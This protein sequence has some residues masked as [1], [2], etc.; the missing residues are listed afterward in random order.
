[1]V[2]HVEGELVVLG[3]SR[4]VVQTGGVGFE[5]RIPLSTYTALK[6]K[7]GARV[8]ILTHLQVLEDDLRL[9]GFATERERDLFRLLTSINGV[10][11]ATAL[12][13]LA[14]IDPAAFAALIAAGDAK[15]L[16][17]I[18]GIGPKLSERL[19]VELKDRTAALEAL[20]GA[21][22]GSAARSAG[23]PVAPAVVDEAV[24]ALL[25]MG[26]PA[27]EAKGRVEAAIGKLFGGAKGAA[28]GEPG[29]TGSAT[30]EAIILAA[31]RTRD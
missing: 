3:P 4:A 14:S 25:V 11:P 24:K 16:Q 1:M 12:V 27:R 20:A 21:A 22:G 13:V 19:I 2:H 26:F 31:L 28:S 30:V 10:G 18:K 23:S 15:P 9:F 17:K 29:P 7:E 5:V 6:G 8:R